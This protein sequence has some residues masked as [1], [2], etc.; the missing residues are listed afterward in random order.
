MIRC[1]AGSSVQV[2]RPTVLLA[3]PDRLRGAL[4]AAGLEDLGVDVVWVPNGDTAIDAAEQARF[5]VHVVEPSLRG[6]HRERVVEALVT[7]HP[8][9]PLVV[10]GSSAAVVHLASTRIPA[11]DVVDL[12]RAALDSRRASQASGWNR[13]PHHARA[14]P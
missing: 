3:E 13:R 10:T 8:S 14:H 12:V 7:E 9:V 1:E 11:A 6:T 5:D 4:I 2:S